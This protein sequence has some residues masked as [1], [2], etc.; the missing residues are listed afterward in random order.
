M[1]K[2]VKKQKTL[3]GRRLL[4]E[5]AGLAIKHEF[6][7]EASWTLST[8]FAMK[9]TRFIERWQPAEKAAHLTFARMI[10]TAKKVVVT[11]GRSDRPATDLLVLF[12]E[13][14]GWKNLRNELLKDIR[15]VQVSQARLERLASEG[16]RLYAVLG[17]AT[18]V[19]RNSGSHPG[20]A[21]EE[22]G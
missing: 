11:S 2:K 12:D 10:R 8:L 9:L 20:T 22:T 21:A 1:K 19:Y 15:E 5:R 16:A 13:I 17:K 3:S 18:K 14:R 6:Y 4:L 7:L